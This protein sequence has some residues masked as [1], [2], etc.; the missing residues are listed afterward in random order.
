MFLLGKVAR[1][2][3]SFRVLR[4]RN[5]RKGS[6]TAVRPLIR[7]SSTVEQRPVKAMVAGSNPASGA[8]VVLIDVCL[9]IYI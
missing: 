5:P 2:A 1:V 7:S 6:Y 8:R 3:D 9:T 4:D